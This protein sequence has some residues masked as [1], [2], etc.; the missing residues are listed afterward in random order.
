M[1]IWRYWLT[2]TRSLHCEVVAGKPFEENFRVTVGSNVS[3]SEAMDRLEAIFTE[4]AD[5]NAKGKRYSEKDLEEHRRRLCEL[6]GWFEDGE[7]VRPIC[8]SVIYE[9]DSL[10]VVT[11]NRYGAEVLNSEETCFIDIDHVR[12]TFGESLRAIFGVARSPED[13]LVARMEALLSRSENADL[14]FRLYRT[15]AGFRLVVEGRRLEPDGPRTRTLMA[16]F[17]ADHLYAN[18]CVSQKCYRARLTPKP[19]RMKMK[20]YEG[21][22]SWIEEYDRRR[23]D[24]A[25]CKFVCAKGRRLDSPA[26]ALHDEKTL[27]ESGL[28]LA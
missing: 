16:F 26:I 2:E 20:R 15:A 28:P 12:R 19:W 25:V 11:R 5:W 1:K 4:L 10:N 13:V 14:G 24:Y 9:Q 18:L 3:E 22:N 17:N 6:H 21:G 23:Q 7:Y 8:E 27:C